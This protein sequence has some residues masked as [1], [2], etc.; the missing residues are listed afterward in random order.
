MR[1]LATL[2]HDA[3][4]YHLQALSAPATESRPQLFELTSCYYSAPKRN[5]AAL[6]IFMYR[7]IGGCLGQIH[8]FGV[9]LK[10]V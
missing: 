5:A 8:D 7:R 2:Q 9:N 3:L 10:A 6:F 4:L 1:P